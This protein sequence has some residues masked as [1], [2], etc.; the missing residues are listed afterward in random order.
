MW[1]YRYDHLFT[2]VGVK[3]RG[4]KVGRSGQD[5]KGNFCYLAQRM[6]MSSFGFLNQ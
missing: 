4:L 1:A 3:D 5:C 2:G 6:A